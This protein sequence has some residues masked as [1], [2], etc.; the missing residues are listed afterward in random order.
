ML[1]WLPPLPLFS[2]VTYLLHGDNLL[3]LVKCDIPISSESYKE[4]AV[5]L[6][7][8]FRASSNMAHMSADV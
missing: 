4:K 7:S 2:A 8:L 1:P 5:V 6:Y 3:K